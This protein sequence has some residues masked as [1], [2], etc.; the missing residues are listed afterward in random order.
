M[1][2]WRALAPLALIAAVVAI[3]WGTYSA[4]RDAGANAVRATYEQ[5]LAT[6]RRTHTAALIAAERKAAADM[7]AITDRMQEDMTRAQAETE[8][9]AAAV[10]DGRERLRERFICPADGVPET[11]ASAGSS[12]AGEA[13]GLQR[14][15]AE[16]L[17]RLAAE[18]DAA[19][20]QLTACQDILSSDRHARGVPE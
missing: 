11:S 9:L 8:R 6:Q 13:R 3:L 14:A 4:G 7:T 10:R 1:I 12:D 15:D 16:F 19:A 18:A 20:T 2:G 17:V 5:E